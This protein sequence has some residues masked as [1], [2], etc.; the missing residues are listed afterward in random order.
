MLTDR[1]KIWNRRIFSSC[2]IHSRNTK[3]CMACQC[4]GRTNKILA[5]GHNPL[6]LRFCPS[7]SVL[8]VN[9]DFIKLIHKIAKIEEPSSKPS[10][11]NSEAKVK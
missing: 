11:G 10:S 9:R 1:E 7:C 5:Y 3:K 8:Y 6:E 4:S 2:K